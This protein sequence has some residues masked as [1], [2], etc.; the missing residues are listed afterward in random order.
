[1]DKNILKCSICGGKL[2]FKDKLNGILVCR[3]CGNEIVSEL[4]FKEEKN[5]PIA[6]KQ[7]LMQVQTFDE[8]KKENSSIKKNKKLQFVRILLMIL[9]IIYVLATLCV[10]I[11]S[12]LSDEYNLILKNQFI[13]MAISWAV[14]FVSAILLRVDTKI[15]SLN[16]LLCIIGIC[17][18]IAAGWFVADYYFFV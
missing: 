1:M 18:V 9:S 15:K 14:A 10:V 12:F 11:Y 13:A 3:N 5:I 16:L 6:K 17:F 4:S 8:L 7:E 2:E